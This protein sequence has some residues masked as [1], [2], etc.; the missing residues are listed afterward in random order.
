MYVPLKT[1]KFQSDISFE[2]C[3]I[4]LPYTKEKCQL[5]FSLLK[6]VN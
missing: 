3:K 2:K 1:T 5:Y 6:E 4:N